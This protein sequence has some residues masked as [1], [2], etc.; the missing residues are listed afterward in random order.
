M[1]MW[2]YKVVDFNSEYR[3]EHEENILNTM[4]QQGWE[5]VAVIGGYEWHPVAYL[6]Q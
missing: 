5:L 1:V 4:G 6:R 2:Q 3:G